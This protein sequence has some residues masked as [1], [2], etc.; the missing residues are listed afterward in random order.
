MT[1]VTRAAA[2]RGMVDRIDDILHAE[3]KP[4]KRQETRP[5]GTAAACRAADAS[6]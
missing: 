6:T 4:T 5:I 1:G 2:F 3:N